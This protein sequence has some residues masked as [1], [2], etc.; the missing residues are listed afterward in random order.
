MLLVSVCHFPHCRTNE[1]LAVV[2]IAAN[3]ICRH[4]T[5]CMKIPTSERVIV[6][7]QLRFL[8]S[9][10]A[11]AVDRQPNARLKVTKSVFPQWSVSGSARYT[12]RRIASV[13]FP[14]P[15]VPR[16][17]KCPCGDKHNTSFCL[18]I[19][20]GSAI[21]SPLQQQIITAWWLFSKRIQH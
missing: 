12:A 14:L 16:T 7:P 4:F 21:Q 2:G 15:A 1:T 6:L 9:D 13:V 3:T 17:A 11:D 8:V 19:G 20:L 18:P 10:L 5:A